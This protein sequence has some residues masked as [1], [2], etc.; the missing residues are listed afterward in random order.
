MVSMADIREVKN[1]ASISLVVKDRLMIPLRAL[2][3]C[4]I[5]RKTLAYIRRKYGLKRWINV[6]LTYWIIT[7]EN[8]GVG[9]LDPLYKFFPSLTPY[10]LEIEVE[11][12]TICNINCLQC[13]YRHWDPKLRLPD[14]RSYKG[15]NLTFEQFKHM[16]DQ[17]PHLI[18]IN[19][20]GEGSPFL[21]PEFLQMLEYLKKRNVYVN[22]SAEAYN[23]NHEIAK[24]LVEIG[25]DKIWFSIDGA[26]KE[27]YQKIRVGS[28]WETIWKNIRDLIEEKRKAKSYLPQVCFHFTP[29]TLNRHEIIPFIDLVADLKEEYGIWVGEYVT[30][31]FQQVIINNP[32]AAELKYEPT[33]EEIEKVYEHAKKRGVKIF[34]QRPSYEEE[35]KPPGDLCVVWKEPFFLINGDVVPCCACVQRNNRP[36]LH[37]FTFG[38]LFE[39]PFR[40]IWDS[41]RYKKFRK[42]VVNPKAPVPILC[43]GCAVFN[44]KDR[45]EK[46]G[47]SKEI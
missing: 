40:E 12:T 15:Q 31:D 27:T 3:L 25:V 41:D 2:R 22:F 19:P 28:D 9:V 8:S 36:W 14:G 21:N 43:Q 13:E 29:M 10:P 35:T 17:F 47:I 30:I 6:V 5:N 7:G 42:M 23:W 20:T 4:W 38:N 45:R 46:Y 16:V 34:Y 11:F 32:K 44:F 18:W 33:D 24:K 1:K 26:T 37:E 39:K